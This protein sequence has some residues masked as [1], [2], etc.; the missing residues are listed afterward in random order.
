[1]I[2]LVVAAGTL[3]IQG[4]TLPWLVRRL[5]LRGPDPAQDAV[6][7]GPRA[8]RRVERRARRARR[9]ADRRRADPRSSSASR[10]RS[11]SAGQQRLG[12]ARRRRATRRRARPYRA[13]AGSR[14]CEAE[15]AS[16]LAARDAAPRPTRCCGDVLDALDIEESILTG[17][18]GRRRAR[19][20]RARRAGPARRRLRAPAAPPRAVPSRARPQGCE[21]CLRDGTRWVHLRLCLTCGHVGCCDS[22]T[23]EH[24]DRALPR[25]RAPGDAQLRAGRGMALVL[26]RR[27]VGMGH[28]TRSSRVGAPDLDMVGDGRMRPPGFARLKVLARN[29]TIGLF[30]VRTTEPC[31]AVRYRRRPHGTSTVAAP[32]AWQPGNPRSSH[33]WVACTVRTGVRLFHVDGSRRSQPVGG[34]RSRRHRPAVVG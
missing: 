2:A 33:Y 18:D 28:G 8:S 23:A 15:R 13:A 3:L 19:R 11:P 20:A 1:M 6:A 22:S 32:G 31:R 9:A 14:C 21:E 7:G 17:P 29:H 34:R 25:D 12:A 24:A 26:R 4:S 27:H 10:Q 16:V 5:G 30:H